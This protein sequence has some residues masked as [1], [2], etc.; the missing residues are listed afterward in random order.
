M[1][2][3]SYFFGIYIRIHWREHGV[4]HFHANYAEH[5]VVISINDL[6]ILEGSLPAR[7]LALVIEW[8]V[9]HKEE[10]LENYELG[11]QGKPFNKIEPLK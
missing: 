9:I 10:L 7:A 3:I 5:E 8:A 1:P 11:K 6:A 2:T 4:A